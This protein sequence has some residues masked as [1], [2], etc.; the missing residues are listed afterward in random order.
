MIARRTSIQD[1]THPKKLTFADI[2]IM[3][4]PSSYISALCVLALYAEV[5]CGT[6]EQNIH[7]VLYLKGR[8]RY[9]MWSSNKKKNHPI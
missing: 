7:H 4:H 9:V 3:H 1:S 8:K 5:D 2:N 6:D